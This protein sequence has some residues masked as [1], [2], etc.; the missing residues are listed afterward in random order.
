MLRRQSDNG[1]SRN[2]DDKDKFEGYEKLIAE[3]TRIRDEI[4]KNDSL[5]VTADASKLPDAFKD[6]IF[7]VNEILAEV[8]EKSEY[9]MTRFQLVNQA[10]KV[11]LWD[12]DVV[13][14]DS[15]NPANTFHWSDELRHL[16]GY[17]DETDFPNVLSSWIDKIH[18]D[19]KASVVG[20]FRKHLADRTGRTPY[21]LEYRLLKK[22][23]TYSDFHAYG[24]TIRDRA[25]NALRV[26]GALEDI[27]AKKNLE[28]E[29][30][31]RIGKFSD[32]I[33]QMTANINA[34]FDISK[35]IVSAQEV[36]LETSQKSEAS[37]AESYSILSVVKN[38]AS[39]TSML[40]INASIEAAKS[41][42]VGL[43]FKVVA[44][45][46]NKLAAESKKS[47]ESVENKLIVMKENIAAMVTDISSTVN[48]VKQQNSTVDNLKTLTDTI[49][50]LYSGLIDVLRKHS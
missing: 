23:G 25:G 10:S 22:D 1:V 32:A 8:K 15:A 33:S 2:N 41:G 11:G 19:E 7:L 13:G 28:R 36:N 12:M 26:A 9:Q 29:L 44:E 27:T 40:G 50:N 3:L 42:K 5:N 45:E 17:K 14:G 39:R 37:I 31:S 46:I 18:P 47:A 16:L 43:G 34:I 35:N 30:E 6:V 21:D 48:L 49:D 4:I 38:I 24:A 20:Q